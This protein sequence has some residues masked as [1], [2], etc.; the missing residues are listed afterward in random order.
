MWKHFFSRIYKRRLYNLKENNCVSFSFFFFR[1]PPLFPYF[2]AAC[3]TKGQ[4]GGHSKEQNNP[5]F[6][7]LFTTR[8]RF[9]ASHPVIKLPSYDV[10][11]IN[12]TL[13][14]KSYTKWKG[15]NVRTKI[16]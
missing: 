5:I 4:K 10:F 7:L 2:P 11:K 13:F 1:S 3:Q 6:R 14:S 8:R 15:R 16:S 12:D 9:P